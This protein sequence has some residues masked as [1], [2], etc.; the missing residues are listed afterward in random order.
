[1][2]FPNSFP[3]NA[4]YRGNTMYDVDIF[5]V[6]EAYQRGGQVDMNLGRFLTDEV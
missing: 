2:L 1:M 5:G 4:I 3:N 6:E